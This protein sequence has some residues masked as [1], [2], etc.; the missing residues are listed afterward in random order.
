MASTLAADASPLR[1]PVLIAATRFRLGSKISELWQYRE[2]FYFLI[3]R[4]VKVRY[5][6]SVLGV[7]WAVIQPIVPM[8]IFSVVFGRV[9]RISSDGAPYTLFAYAGL[10]PWTYFANAVG[11]SSAS[12]VREVNLLSKIY[13]PRLLIPLTSV[14]A[15]LMDLIIS[16]VFLFLL[17]VWYHATPTPAVIVVPALILLTTVVASGLGLWLSAL[18][19][20]YRD[21]RYAVPFAIQFFMYAAPV[22]YPTSLIPMQYRYLYAVNPMVGIIEGTRASLLGLTPIPWDLIAIATVSALLMTW[23]GAV[24]FIRK[25]A[26]FADVA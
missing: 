7:G 19:L 5:A 22:V 26:V 8:V 10:V 11:D 2:L 18:A 17:M 15:R 25:E 23:R 4:D 1:T 9:A 13:F 3:W 21:I 12:L 6:Q 14:L 20:Q 24:Y 16:F